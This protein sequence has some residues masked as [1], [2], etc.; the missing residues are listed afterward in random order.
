MHLVRCGSVV[1][2]LALQFSS[3]V[4]ENKVLS[5]IKDAAKDGMLGDFS[6][7]TSSIVGTRPQITTTLTTLQSSSSASKFWLYILL[8]REELVVI[9]P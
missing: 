8:F 4:Q 9:S 5:I 3:V 2:D 7:N 6:V 1:V